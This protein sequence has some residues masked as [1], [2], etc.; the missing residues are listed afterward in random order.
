MIKAF[1]YLPLYE[2]KGHSEIN[3]KKV[4]LC[5][6]V[7]SGTPMVVCENKVFT[8]TWDEIL[9]KAYKEGIAG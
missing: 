7:A 9:E 4:R 2:E 8:M 1:K 3:G 5:V 6:N